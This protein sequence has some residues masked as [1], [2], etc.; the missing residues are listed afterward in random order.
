MEILWVLYLTVCGNFNCMTQE[1]QRFENQAKCVAS[2]AMHEMI[3]VDGN[4][5]KVSYRCRP[6]D[7]IDV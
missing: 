4:F 3:P 1:V 5:K 6:K 7:S 2:Q